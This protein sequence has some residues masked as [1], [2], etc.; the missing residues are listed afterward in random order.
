[1]HNYAILSLKALGRFILELLYFP[2]WW[3]SFGAWNF[4]SKQLNYLHNQE[5]SLALFVWIKNIL[6][7]MYGQYD[8]AGL[9]I[10]FIVRSIQIIFRGSYLSI[11]AVISLSLIIAWLALP[12]L[13][14]KGLIYQVS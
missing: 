4:L 3:Y 10:S 8:I 5:K 13:V 11:L 9:T 7:P 2:V 14:I 1:M 6:K 12:I